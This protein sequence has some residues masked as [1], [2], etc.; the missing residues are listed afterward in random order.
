MVSREDLASRQAELLHALLARGP[1]PAGFDEAR[2]HVEADVLRR[3]RTRLIAYL[4]PDLE[5]ALGDRFAPLFAEFTAGQPKTDTIRTHAYADE[6][7]TWLV[8]RG[9]LPRPKRRFPWRR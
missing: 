6:F 2:L 7:T 1:V 5:E 3:K 4:R 8:D 9:D